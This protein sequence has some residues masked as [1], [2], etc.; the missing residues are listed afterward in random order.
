MDER[1]LQDWLKGKETA[2]AC[3]L[4][5]RAALRVVP[6]MVFALH[7]NEGERRHT[8]VIPSFRALAA[9]NFSG[10][11]HGRA[12]EARNVARSA[13]QEA[14]TAIEYLANDA[15]MGVVEL[16][17]A[18]PELNEQIWRCE[19]DACNL[20]IAGSAI[21][22]V[23]EATQ[24]VVAKVDA[25]E[26]IGSPTAVIAAAIESVRSA[27]TAIDGI[28]RDTEFY[29]D[30]EEDESSANVPR[31]IAEFWSAVALDVEWLDACVNA[32]DK[33]EVVVLGLSE[34]ELW[35]DGIPV[36]AGKLWA[37]FKDRL[38]EEEGW[39]VWNDWYEARL[40][41]HKLDAKLETDLLNIAVEDWKQGPAHVNTIIAKLIRPPSDP[42]LTAIAYGF[43]NL[44]QVK[45]ISSIDLQLY[46]DRIRN[47]LPNDPY[48]AIGATKEM[49]EAT[50]KSILDRRQNDGTDELNFSNLTTQC[51]RELRLSGDSSPATEG[52]RHVRKIASA[53]QRMI[54][55]ANKLRNSAGT[56]H[57]R[58]VG[59]EPVVTAADATLVASVGIILAAW[60]LHHDA[61]S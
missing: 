37:D 57:G 14:R 47:A 3:V 55:V 38:P 21:D 15:Q 40:K 22:A 13:G 28:H 41:G 50:M 16:R 39:E 20:M 31:H 36:W 18:V 17:E 5:T 33:S 9:A 4:A 6:I 35:L 60:L 54:E 53:A 10:A 46:S 59:K 29:D 52:E 51:L 25:E 7:E 48:Q 2:F 45:Q 27:R 56:G 24:S 23:V 42:L 26:G 58:V 43:D 1:A 49:L 32:N 8:I 30:L 44:E 34:K 11:W 19:R 12:G 61:E